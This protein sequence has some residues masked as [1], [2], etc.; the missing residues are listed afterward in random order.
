MDPMRWRMATIYADA[1][2]DTYTAGTGTASCIGAAAPAGYRLAAFGNDCND[3]DPALHTPLPAYADVDQDGFGAGAIV[4]VCAATLPAG[5]ATNNTDVCATDATATTAPHVTAETTHG[6]R[7]NEDVTDGTSWSFLGT[8]PY[9]NLINLNENVRS[10]W[11]RLRQYGFALPVA[12]KI[13][14]IAVRIEHA[15][16]S[17]DMI[18]VR[19]YDIRLYHG[20][21]RTLMN[22]ASATTWTESAVESFNYG[23]ATD[24]WGRTWT[25]AE[26]NSSNFGVG[27]RVTMFNFPDPSVDLVGATPQLFAG[28]ITVTYCAQ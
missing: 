9:A 2:G 6:A 17:M 23:G 28:A 27:I 12:A 15:T 24:L 22:R 13:L 4:Q 10:D 20:A 16:L 7:V 8:A 18:A 3:M 14:G 5:Y 25:A 26:I 21:S 11:L 1:D 19:D